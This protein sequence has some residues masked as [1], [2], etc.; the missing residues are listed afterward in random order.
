M[1]SHLR[2]RLEE[3]RP[4]DLLYNTVKILLGV[5]MA[6]PYLLKI[7]LEFDQQDSYQKIELVIE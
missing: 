1:L 3:V 6:Y 4:F 7:D 2:E 5:M